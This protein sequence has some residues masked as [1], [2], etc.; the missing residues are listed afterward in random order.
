MADEQARMSN[1]LAEDIVDNID[2][3]RTARGTDGSLGERLSTMSDNITDTADGLADVTDEV[4][5][6]RGTYS[7][8]E[9]RLAAIEALLPSG[10]GE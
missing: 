10:T 1:Y 3:V 8:L 6:A 9:E 4:H 2:E 5:A 7:T